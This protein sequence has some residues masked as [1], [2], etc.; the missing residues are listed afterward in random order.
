MSK[1]DNPHHSGSTADF[2]AQNS[3]EPGLGADHGLTDNDDY[4][5]SRTSNSPAPVEDTVHN[6]S[7]KNTRPKPQKVER[8]FASGAWAALIVGA[9]LLIMLLIFI[10]QNQQATELN[11]FSWTWN[12]PVGIGM[13]LSAIAGALIM[14]IFGGWRMFELR[15][16]VKKANKRLTQQ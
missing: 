11:L 9:F 16:Q 6:D 8:S 2:P 4:S 5:D 14:A 7:T 10:M 15:R 3:Q 1:S 12:F 13:L